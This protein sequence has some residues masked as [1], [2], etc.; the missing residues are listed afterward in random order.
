MYNNLLP[1]ICNLGNNFPG[2]LFPMTIVL[3]FQWFYA[4]GFYQSIDCSLMKQ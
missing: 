4:F 2:D 1:F 3:F